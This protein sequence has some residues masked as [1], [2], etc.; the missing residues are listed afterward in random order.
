MAASIYYKQT[1][2]TCYYT[3]ENKTGYSLFTPL[4]IDHCTDST[5]S[6]IIEQHSV[7]KDRDVVIELY[8]DKFILPENSR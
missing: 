3:N 1:S 8:N 4:T 6:V 5:T 2:T 7:T